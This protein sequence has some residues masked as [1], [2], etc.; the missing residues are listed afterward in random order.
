MLLTAIMTQPLVVEEIIP[1]SPASSAITLLLTTP[2]RVLSMGTK[3]I[4]MIYATTLNATAATLL[5]EL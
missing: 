3:T 5:L 2:I 1:T 4:P